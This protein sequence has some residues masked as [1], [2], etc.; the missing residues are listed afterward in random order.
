MSGQG[1]GRGCPGWK[2]QHAHR[3]GAGEEHGTVENTKAAHALGI[4]Q[5]RNRVA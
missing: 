5:V 3:P 2:E 4:Q 1:A